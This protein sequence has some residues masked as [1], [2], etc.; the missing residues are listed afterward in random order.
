LRIATRK[1][2]AFGIRAMQDDQREWLHYRSSDEEHAR[3]VRRQGYG[4]AEPERRAGPRREFPGEKRGHRLDRAIERLCE[5]AEA[6]GL[7]IAP[8]VGERPPEKV[9]KTS[10]RSATVVR[11]NALLERLPNVSKDQFV[12]EAIRKFT[13]VY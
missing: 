4:K 6:N 7:T 9:R 10:V 11:M 3:L 8:L 1:A 2:R 5:E 12:R 13:R